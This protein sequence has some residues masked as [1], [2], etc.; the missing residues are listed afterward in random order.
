MLLDTEP[1]RS[2]SAAENEDPAHGAATREQR[3]SPG[4]RG[5]DISGL[6]ETRL[7]LLQENSEQYHVPEGSATHD[8]RRNFGRTGGDRASGNTGMGRHPAS[9]RISAVA[10]QLRPAR[11]GA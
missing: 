1:V 3:S 9:I 8:Q 7:Q 6:A 2:P 11:T 5:N 4:A 10:E